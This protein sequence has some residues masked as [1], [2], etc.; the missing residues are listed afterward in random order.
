MKKSFFGP[1]R[2]NGVLCVSRS[3][4]DGELKPYVTDEPDVFQ[5]KL[6]RFFPPCYTVYV[7]LTSYA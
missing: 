5:R 7:V 1:S 4:G 2:V 6:E 3:L